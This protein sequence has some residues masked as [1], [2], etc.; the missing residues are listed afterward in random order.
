MN[1]FAQTPRMRSPLP[2]V[3]LLSAALSPPFFS[4]GPQPRC[5]ALTPS[6]RPP[7]PSAFSLLFRSVP[8]FTLQDLWRGNLTRFYRTSA[9]PRQQAEPFRSNRRA[10]CAF[11]TSIGF[12][13]TGYGMA[14]T[15]C[16]L[17]LTQALPLQLQP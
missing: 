15:R 12:Q 4:C 3:L 8:G 11:A 1:R 5:C 7:K 17:A 13:G 2:P 9:D 6:A 14:P 10:V 16:A